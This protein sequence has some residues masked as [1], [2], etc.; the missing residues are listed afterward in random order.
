MLSI[1][2]FDTLIDKFVLDIKNERYK[3]VGSLYEIIKDIERLPK[4]VQYDHIRDIEKI[5]TTINEF[6]DPQQILG[7][8]R[9]TA[10][11]SL[12]I[13]QINRKEINVTKENINKIDEHDLIIETTQQLLINLNSNI[14]SSNVTNYIIEYL[15]ILDMILTEDHDKYIK[16]Y[17]DVMRILQEQGWVKDHGFQREPNKIK[18]A[19]ELN[20]M[21]I[22]H[23]I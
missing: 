21:I 12:L 1:T 10:L 17:N 18:L 20:K 2:N 9:I 22:F 15:T 13:C 7:E 19:E 8:N 14:L 6:G 16:F 3:T 5:V 11:L 4:S 23:T